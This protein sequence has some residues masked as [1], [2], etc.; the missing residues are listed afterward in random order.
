MTRPYV[1]RS[2]VLLNM[3]DDVRKKNISFFSQ[4]LMHKPHLDNHCLISACI[5]LS[6]LTTFFVKV[7]E[8]PSKTSIPFYSPSTLR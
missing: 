1:L 2:I 6:L 3:D 8:K 4:H 7:I 5:A